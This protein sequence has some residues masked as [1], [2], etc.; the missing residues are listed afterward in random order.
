MVG[1]G[2]VEASAA[3]G[4]RA[5]AYAIANRKLWF[6]L[7]PQPMQICGI[8]AGGCRFPAVGKLSELWILR[9]MGWGLLSR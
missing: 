5:S 7:L 2:G 9:V 3:I 1:C 4:M 6:W 8:A